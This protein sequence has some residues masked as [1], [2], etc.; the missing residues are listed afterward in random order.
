MT[1][2]HSLHIVHRGAQHRHPWRPE[3]VC[4]WAG[5]PRRRRHGAEQQYHA[6]LHSTARK[7]HPSMPRALTS[8][9]RL[10]EALR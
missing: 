5:I 3:C 6:H 9:D 4:G 10:P 2:H 7:A 1:V 8:T